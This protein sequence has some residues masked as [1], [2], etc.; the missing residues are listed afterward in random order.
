LEGPRRLKY[1]RPLFLLIFVADDIARL[2]GRNLKDLITSVT[3]QSLGKCCSFDR[4]AFSHFE[5][6]VVRCDAPCFQE[7]ELGSGQRP[8]TR[9]AS[10]V[11]VHRAITRTAIPR[12]LHVNSQIHK[13]PRLLVIQ[14]VFESIHTGR[15]IGTNRCR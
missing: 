10:R 13:L 15:L 9:Q 14:S 8:T 3:I 12:A 7:R 1:E 4:F 2:R 6:F 5:F 11:S